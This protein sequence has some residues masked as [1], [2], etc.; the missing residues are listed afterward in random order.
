[1]LSLTFDAMRVTLIRA[2]SAEIEARARAVARR[3]R[4]RRGSVAHDHGAV[5]GAGRHDRLQ[6]V[7]GPGAAAGVVRAAEH[8]HPGA[9]GERALEAG[10]VHAVAPAVEHQR[11]FHHLAPVRADAQGERVVDGRL[12]DDAVARSARRDDRGGYRLHHPGSGYSARGGAPPT[13]GAWASHPIAASKYDSGSR[14]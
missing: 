5:P 4:G 12:D 11:V 8:Q 3:A 7:A 6:L 14:V 9:I 13:R 10:D 2:A 1:M